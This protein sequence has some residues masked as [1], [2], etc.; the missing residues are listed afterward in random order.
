LVIKAARPPA[1]YQHAVKAV[2]DDAGCYT[3]E[4]RLY[5]LEGRD[6]TADGAYRYILIED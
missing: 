1:T 6:D 2:H 3:V 5:R 4:K